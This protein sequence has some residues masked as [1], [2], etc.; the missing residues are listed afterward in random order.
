MS[1][2]NIQQGTIK[3]RKEET[4]DLILG[5]V[6]KDLALVIFAVIAILHWSRLITIPYIGEYGIPFADIFK[7]IFLSIILVYFVAWDKLRNILDKMFEKDW[8][9]ILLSDARGNV[10]GVW[11]TDPETLNK[12]EDYVEFEDE[13]D[14]K[15]REGIDVHGRRYALIRDLKYNQETGTWLIENIDDYPEKVDDDQMISD[16]EELKIFEDTVLDDAKEGRN[17]RKALPLIRNK[18][19]HEE[20]KDAVIGLS[21]ALTGSSTDEILTNL[22]PDYQSEEEKLEEKYAKEDKRKTNVEELLKEGYSERNRG[23]E[24]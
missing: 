17:L 9:Y 3:N 1:E 24:Q 6:S 16:N 19:R 8:A 10:T 13:H 18:V 20:A 7:I 4:K 5:I 23:D 15:Y 21:K 14:I 22:V 11:K 12:F 2:N